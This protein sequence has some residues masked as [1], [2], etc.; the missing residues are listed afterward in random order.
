MHKIDTSAQIHPTA[1]IDNDVTIGK[2]DELGRLLFGVNAV[3]KS[4]LMKSI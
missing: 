4:S 3:G 1:I 2:V